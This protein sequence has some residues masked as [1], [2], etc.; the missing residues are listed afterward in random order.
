M[1]R[2]AKFISRIF[3]NI[4]PKKREQSSS[5]SCEEKPIPGA[6]E[7]DHHRTVSPDVF[8]VQSSD[9][10]QKPTSYTPDPLHELLSQHYGDRI[11][12][13]LVVSARRSKAKA[14][15]GR[16]FILFDLVDN[17]DPSQLRRLLMLDQG[18]HG[19][20][21]LGVPT[22]SQVYFG[23]SKGGSEKALI[24]RCGYDDYK[25]LESMTFNPLINSFSLCTLMALAGAVSSTGRRYGKI[26]SCWF[27]TALWSCL[28]EVQPTAHQ[29]N[30]H[31]RAFAF[32]PSRKPM[33]STNP[34]SHAELSQIILEAKRNEL[35]REH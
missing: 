10:P 2:C 19:G 1:A 25:T 13:L 16:E 22:T 7:T 3:R 31:K 33:C 27:T 9:E 15:N 17:R 11:E 21:L 28:K 14:R 35:V 18:Q 29:V 26:S 12:H 20:D 23:V 24:Q 5:I 30:H 34:L 8:P 6:C 4:S 32:F